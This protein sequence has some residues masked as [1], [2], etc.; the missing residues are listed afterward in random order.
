MSDVEVDDFLAHYGIP[1]M[2]WGQRKSAVPGVSSKTNREAAKDAKEYTQAKM[3]FGE[4]AGVRRRLI[5][6]SIKSKMKDE[7]YK[8]AFDHH[9]SNTDMSKRA[10]QARGTRKR[11]DVVKGT[12]KTTRGVINV[13]RGNPRFASAA[14]VALVAG[15]TFAHKKGIDKMLLDKG[16]VAFKEAAKSPAAAAVRAAFISRFSKD[17]PDLWG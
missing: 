14:A 13:L 1:G 2:H 15:A 8:K 12:K 5:N 9:V 6:N 3:Y 11:T 7:A 17:S 10:E 16:K 4:G